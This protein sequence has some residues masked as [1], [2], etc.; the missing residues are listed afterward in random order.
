[1]TLSTDL[2]AWADSGGIIAGTGDNIE[3][4]VDVAYEDGTNPEGVF[5]RVVIEDSDP[6]SDTLT[7]WEELQLGYNPNHNDT[8]LDGIPDNLDADPLTAATLSDPDGLGLPASLETDLEGRW[9]FETS[10]FGTTSG[11]GGTPQTPRNGFWNAN[12]VPGGL[13]A[14]FSGIPDT[15]GMV[16]KAADNHDDKFVLI[17]GNILDGHTAGFAMKLLGE[18]RSGRDF[19]V[20]KPLLSGTVDCDRT[21]QPR[22]RRGQCPAG[23]QGRTGG[24]VVSRRLSMDGQRRSPEFRLSRPNAPLPGRHPR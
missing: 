6:D 8:D 12:Q 10:F 17:D 9:D 14:M 15:L 13:P 4:A 20:D 3:I 21:G 18:A 7:T 11:A 24:R 19:P 2:I 22:L 16:S 23:S 1:M 5:W